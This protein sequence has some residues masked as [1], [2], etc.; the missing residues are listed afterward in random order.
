[1]AGRV[2][3]RSCKVEGCSREWNAR[4]YCAMHYKIAKKSGELAEEIRA[5]NRQA[6]RDFLADL[7]ALHRNNPITQGINW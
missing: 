5:I 4:G 7:V 2:I 1:M 3:D 6:R